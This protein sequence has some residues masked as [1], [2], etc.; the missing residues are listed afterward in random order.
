MKTRFTVNLEQPRRFKALRYKPKKSLFE[1]KQG[2]FWFHV[3]N[4]ILHLTN[5]TFQKYATHTEACDIAISELYAISH[6]NS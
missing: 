3:L 1:S 5:L 2:Q 6:R 4:L